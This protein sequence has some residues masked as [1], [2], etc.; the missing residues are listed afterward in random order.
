MLCACDKWE[1]NFPI[2]RLRTERMTMS[3]KAELVRGVA[4]A[5]RTKITVTGSEIDVVADAGA[6]KNM[7]GDGSQFDRM[8][9]LAG[10]FVSTN[11]L[12]GLDVKSLKRIIISSE[13]PLNSLDMVEPNEALF[14]KLQIRTPLMWICGES[15]A[16][17]CCFC[18]PL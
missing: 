7:S 16:C 4:V 13:M 10:Q 8:Q 3:D 14:K 18:L 1:L 15:E 6:L 5:A 2:D 11:E 17:G 9:G 12:L